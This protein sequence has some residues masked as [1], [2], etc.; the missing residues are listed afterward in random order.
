MAA[1]NVVGSVVGTRMAILKGSRFVRVFF[2]LVVGAL[3]AKLA[4]QLF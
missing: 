3:I 4:Q 2:L 1:C